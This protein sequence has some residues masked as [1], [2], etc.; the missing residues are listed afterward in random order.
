MV[1]ALTLYYLGCEVT[2]LTLVGE[3]PSHYVEVY[4]LLPQGFDTTFIRP[5]LQRNNRTWIA[6]SEEQNI[7]TFVDPSPMADVPIALVGEVVSEFV[8]SLDILYLSTEH[9]PVI[10]AALHAVQSLPCKVVTNVNA[11]LIS[12]PLDAAAETLKETIKLSHT[13]VMNESE[14]TQALSKLGIERWLDVD[15]DNLCEIVV[16]R[17]GKGGYFT[18]H[19]FETWEA[20]QPAKATPVN[21]VVGAGD[22][23]NGAFIKSR[24]VDLS[25]IGVS[26]EYA[27]KVAAK[28]VELD[29][30]SLL[31]ALTH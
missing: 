8:S 2:T 11:P 9:L 30:C 24:F 27:A 13:I 20:Y 7:Y 31:P 12:D 21:C 14:S 29:A 3:S 26:C 1:T 25:S 23:F 22:T 4:A 15:S 19:P 10:Q 6:V 18:S 16:T 5:W 28:K 17:G